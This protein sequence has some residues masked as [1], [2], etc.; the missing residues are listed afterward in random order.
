MGI[1]PSKEADS[2]N[3]TSANL[4]VTGLSQAEAEKLL[5]QYGAKMQF[6]KRK[7]AYGW[8]S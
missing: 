1:N 6:R 7:C 4:Q 5:Q 8:F 2:E 3:I